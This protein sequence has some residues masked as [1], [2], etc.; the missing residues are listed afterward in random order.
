MSIYKGYDIRGIVPSEINA[1][2]AYTLGCAFACY[3]RNLK[4]DGQK[5]RILVSRDNRSTSNELS[6]QLIAGL[7]SQGVQCIDI[8]LAA[9]PIFYFAS[10][11]LGCDGGIMVTASHNPAQYNGFKIVREESIPI[12]LDSGLLDIQTLVERADFPPQTVGSVEKKEIID[13]YI[14]NQKNILEMTD[15]KNLTIAI[16]TGNGVSVSMIKP[17]METLNTHMIP[18]YFEMDGTFPNHEPNPLKYE[19]IKDLCELVRSKK[20]DCGIALDADGDRVIFVDEHGEPVS[21]DFISALVIVE[22]LKNVPGATILY[23]VRSSHVVRETIQEHGGTP[24]VTRV[25][26]AYIKERMRSLDALFT[27]EVSGHFYFKD[28]H[29]YEAPLLTIGMILKA[30]MK[31]NIPLS[32]LIAPYKKYCSTGE[33]NFTVSDKDAVVRRIKDHFAPDAKVTS[34]IDGITM[35]FDEWWFN[36]RLSNTEDVLRL[37]ME[38]TSQEMCDDKRAEIENIIKQ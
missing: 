31:K 5:L 37:N 9:T 27:G 21:S 15:T 16:D 11:H 17:F 38:A 10:D 19:N 26:H 13:Q 33:V 7:M 2:L 12:G 8:G 22:L 30:M 20:A 36:V 14:V 23:D 18:L 24:H 6:E 34:E 1:D 29:Y 25:G 4:T 3:I 32:Q 35:E 28:T